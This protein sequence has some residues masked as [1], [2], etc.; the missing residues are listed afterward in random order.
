[1]LDPTI[2]VMV[3]GQGSRSQSAVDE[4]AQL[5]EALRARFPASPV[6]YGYLEFANPVIR[7]GLDALREAGAQRIEAEAEQVWH[8]PA[9]GGCLDLQQPAEA[10]EAHALRGPAE[11]G[12]VER[13]P[14]AEHKGEEGGQHLCLPNLIARD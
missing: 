1:M 3:C 2:G 4:F 6:A 14:H 7:D 12:R 9:G 11:G 13:I 5:A 8:I 10:V